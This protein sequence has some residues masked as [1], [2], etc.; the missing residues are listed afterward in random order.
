LGSVKRKHS[1]I[2]LDS[3]GDLPPMEKPIIEVQTILQNTAGQT[4]T[5]KGVSII[6]E[7]G[8]KSIR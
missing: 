6:E 4:S 3:V 8:A 7:E 2:K 5:V 1:K